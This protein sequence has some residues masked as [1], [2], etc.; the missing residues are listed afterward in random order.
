MGGRFA[1]DVAAQL[2]S[3]SRRRRLG[4]GPDVPGCLRIFGSRARASAADVASSRPAASPTAVRDVA[5]AAEQPLECGAA[6]AS[7]PPPR[8]VSGSRRGGRRRVAAL[9]GSASG[10]RR[11]RV[12]DAQVTRR[13]RPL[14]GAA[15]QAPEAYLVTAP[16]IAVEGA[17][18]NACN[19]PLPPSH[20]SRSLMRA[21][22]FQGRFM[23]GGR[24]DP[25]CWSWP[26]RES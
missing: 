19:T 17:R 4:P 8:S 5:R 21:V 18:A 1:A 12:V 15:A 20:T 24:L 3:A 13:V 16:H 22:S 10:V 2:R 23:P 26:R 7:P 9:G 25:C 11:Q 14:P 6:A